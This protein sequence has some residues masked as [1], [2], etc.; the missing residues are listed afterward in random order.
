MYASIRNKKNI[1]K[2][3]NEWVNFILNFR[4]ILK[5]L[6][7]MHILEFQNSSWLIALLVHEVSYRLKLPFKSKILHLIL[8]DK[9]FAFGISLN[10]LQWF[11]RYPLHSGSSDLRPFLERWTI[12]NIH[13]LNHVHV[14]ASE[15]KEQ[16]WKINLSRYS[17]DQ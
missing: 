3:F 2:R 8:H 12:G 14:H 1:T 15:S 6:E 9:N 4:Q 11:F 17:I 10:I 7:H 5:S 13:A 16:T